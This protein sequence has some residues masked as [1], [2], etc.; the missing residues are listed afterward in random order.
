MA[1]SA[2]R[3][4]A[5]PLADHTDR[6]GQFFRSRAALQLEIIALRHQLGVTSALGEETEAQ[7]VR[8]VPVAW[9]CGIWDG[10]RSTLC[11]V[12]PGTVMAWHRKGFRLFWTWKVLRGQR[13]R[14][15]VPKEIR[16]L[17]RKMSTENPLWGAPRIHGEL[18]KLGI[19]L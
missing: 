11:L 6:P 19:D 1:Q 16:R 17:I 12:K 8:P 9:L 10:W 15:P 18:L 7:S 4:P 13:G 3:D 14:L 2:D 5:A